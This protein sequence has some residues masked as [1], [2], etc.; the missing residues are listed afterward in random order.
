MSKIYQ[1]LLTHSLFESSESLVRLWSIRAVDHYKGFH[2]PI[3]IYVSL[4]L[5]QAIDDHFPIHC[6]A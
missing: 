3:I 6:T 2:S 5:S 4:S 1:D